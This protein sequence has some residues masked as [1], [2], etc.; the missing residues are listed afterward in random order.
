LQSYIVNGV[1]SKSTKS[2]IAL[3][4]PLTLL[5]LVVYH[6]ENAGIMRIKEIKCLHPYQTLTMDVRKSS[7]A[8]FISE[9]INKCIKEESHAAE[10]CDFLIK[11]LITLDQL[12]EPIENFHLTFLI[13]LSKYLGF[14]PQNVNE[15]LGGRL[16]SAEEEVILKRLLDSD[17]VLSV[18]ISYHSR[19]NLLDALVRFYSSHI[20]NFGEA[21]SVQV[22]HEVLS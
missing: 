5:D 1:R 21:R 13:Q 20:E 14:G 17:H 7:I 6:R 11:S 15:V 2:K 8:L 4:Q 16:V 3:Y 9:M 22:L 19:K 10:L 12:A 18:S